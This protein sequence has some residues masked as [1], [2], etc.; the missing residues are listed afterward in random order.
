MIYV[1]NNVEDRQKAIDEII[2]VFKMTENKE[3]L[4][5]GD[6]YK[7]SCNYDGYL[8]I[9]V[10]EQLT[11]SKKYVLECFTLKCSIN[12]EYEAKA[13]VEDLEIFREI[14]KKYNGEEY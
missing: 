7:Y 9:T 4:T 12:Y 3:F 2:D 6:Y 5:D 1:F 8:T 11:K 14:C 10:Y 13:I